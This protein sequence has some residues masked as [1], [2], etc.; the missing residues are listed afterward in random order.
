MS[1]SG[2]CL[3]MGNLG[4]S[5][6]H[7]QVKKQQI[8][9]NMEQQIDSKLGKECIKP[10]HCYPVHLT[11]MQSSVQ[12]LSC[13]PCNPMECST[14]GFPVHH[15]LCI[16]EEYIVQN[17]GLDASQAGIKIAERNVNNFRYADDNTHMAESEKGE[18]A[19]LKHNIQERKIMASSPITSW[20]IDGETMETVTDFIFLG[21]KITADGD[22]SH[23]IKRCSLEEKL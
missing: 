2:T 21:S 1:S 13:V 4:L 9:P 15:Q 3:K 20:Q 10:V 22:C 14:P 17:A 11:Y 6:F 23:E 19:A 18:F 16:S 5:K 7:L 8:E 12:S